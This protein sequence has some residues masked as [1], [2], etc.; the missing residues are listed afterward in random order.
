[1]FLSCNTYLSFT[2]KRRNTYLHAIYERSICLARSHRPTKQCKQYSWLVFDRSWILSRIKLCSTIWGEAKLKWHVW[3]DKCSKMINNM[4]GYVYFLYKTDGKGNKLSFYNIIRFNIFL[5]LKKLVNHSSH[6]LLRLKVFLMLTF[7]QITL[8]LLH[9][10]VHLL[11]LS[12]FNII[13]T[14]QYNI[15]LSING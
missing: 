14:F 4:A 9:I 10:Y 15:K 6:A 3:N 7:L 13:C 1:M 5:N 12:Q 2:V 11:H 8:F